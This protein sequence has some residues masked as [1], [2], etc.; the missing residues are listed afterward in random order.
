[1]IL[2]GRIEESPHIHPKSVEDFN[3]NSDFFK[4]EYN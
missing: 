4:T 2:L 3:K 1:M